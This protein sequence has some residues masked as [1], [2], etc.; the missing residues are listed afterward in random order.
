MSKMTCTSCHDA[1]QY[2]QKKL[3]LFSQRCINCHNSQHKNVCKMA[4]TLGSLITKNCIDCHMPKQPSMAIAV[5][6]QGKDVP[7][8]AMMRTHFITVYPDE[9]KKFINN[10]KIAHKKRS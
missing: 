8:A 5:L 1:H 2:E 7:S 9:I 4:D 10:L 6:L 3:E